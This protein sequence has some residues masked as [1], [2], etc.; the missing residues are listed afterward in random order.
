MVTLKCFWFF[1]PPTVTCCFNVLY[2]YLPEFTQIHTYCTWRIILNLQ[3]PF[4]SPGP[5]RRRVTV[6]VDLHSSPHGCLTIVQRD[7]AHFRKQ[8]PWPS[9][10]FQNMRFGACENMKVSW[11]ANFRLCPNVN[12]NRGSWIV[13]YYRKKI[14]STFEIWVNFEATNHVVSLQMVGDVRL[15]LCWSTRPPTITKAPFKVLCSALNTS[16]S[17]ECGKVRAT[18]CSHQPQT[19]RQKTHLLHLDIRK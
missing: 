10:A 1:H 15:C 9:P 18:I 6:Q 19:E 2:I 3:E 4:S 8:L 13:Y 16:F 12:W 14:Y 5:K 7:L 17:T 11:W